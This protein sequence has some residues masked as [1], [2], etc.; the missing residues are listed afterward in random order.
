M[1]A[2]RLHPGKYKR[3]HPLLWN[4]VG[5]DR[6]AG[7]L[8]QEWAD[9]FWKF[10]KEIGE[11]PGEHF[12]LVRLREGLYGPDNFEWRDANLRRAPGESVKSWHARKWQSR[13]EAHPGWDFNRKI[14]KIY[15]ITRDQY[16]EYACGAMAVLCERYVIELLEIRHDRRTGKLFG[17]A[18]DHCHTS[19][20]VRGLL[21]RRCNT[22]IGQIN[23]S[24]ELLRA[25]EVYMQQHLNKNLI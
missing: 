4:V 12:S 24:I 1:L 25:M 17:L 8:C 18:I 20:K 10:I 22:T 19:G 14:K 16:N 3:D 21:C 13:K 5:S 9:D 6:K 23:E 15:G 11:K 2:A 7:E